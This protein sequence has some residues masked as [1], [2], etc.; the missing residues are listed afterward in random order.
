MPPLEERVEYPYQ[1]IR[2]KNYPWGD[3]DK[4]IATPPSTGNE[5]LLTCMN[6]DLVVSFILRHN[7]IPLDVPR[8]QMEDLQRNFYKIHLTLPLPH[9]MA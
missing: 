3:G 1:N 6:I 9:S 8:K 2:S 5:E 7:G 4:V